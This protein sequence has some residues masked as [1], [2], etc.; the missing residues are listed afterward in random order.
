[1]VFRFGLRTGVFALCLAGLAACNSSDDGPGNVATGNRAPTVSAGADQTVGE[2]DAVTLAGTASDADGDALTYSWSQTDG[3]GVT[4]NGADTVTASFTAPDVAPGTTITLTFQLTVTD[5]A[6]SATDTVVVNV[7]EALSL[8][9]VSGRLTYERPGFNFRCR[10]LDFNNITLEPVRRAT[11][12]LLDSAGN[13]LAASRTDDNGTYAFAGINANTDVRVRVRAELL[14]TSGPQTW[15]VYVRDN[16]VDTG[17]SFA[18]RPIYVIEWGLFN[19]GITNSTDNDFTA[20]TGW[21]GVAYTGDR[22]AAP[23][24]ILD[25]ILD[26]ILLVTAVD[27]VIDLGRL[28]VFWSIDN[29]WTESDDPAAGQLVTAFY[30]SN[31]EF[32]DDFTRNPSLFLRGDA[33]GRFPDT[34][35]IN[36]DEFDSYVTLHEWGHFFEDE[37]SR[38]DSIGGAHWIPGTV[39]A[40]V[41]FGEGWGNAIGAIASGEVIGCDTGNPANSGSDLNME[42]FNSFTDEQGFFNEMSVATLLYDLWD[43]NNDGADTGSIG[44]GPI[45]ETMT[46]FQRDTAAFTTLFSFAT[47]LRQNVDPNDIAL[48]DALLEQENVDTGNLDAWASGQVTQPDFWHNGKTV[49]D[50]LPLY[51]EI[52]PG[53]PAL[54]LCVNDDQVIEQHGNKPGEWRYLRFTL[55]G[56]Q[57]LTLQIVANP[58]PPDLNPTA[59]ER[60]RAD[61]DVFLYK[62]GVFREAS[63]SGDADQEIFVM[64]SLEP[65]TYTLAFQD[66][67]YEDGVTDLDPPAKHPDYPSRVCFD[68]TLN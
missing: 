4:L 50:L 5:G 53:E 15:E 38:S 34:V 28:D 9:T 51:T 32:P 59:N 30:T 57:N 16:T 58:P 12:L 23:L 29:S 13:E 52:V 48:V 8:V 18:T 11:V 68:F 10:G 45:Y 46:G 6:A 31:P 19:T 3:P 63:R 47:G 44:F 66:W 54:N 27:P 17:P 36:T 56:T 24:A 22:A 26:G 41:A 42:T 35:A 64:G 43:T 60:D 14:Q 7:V 2:G 39:E 1:M 55:A 33:V 49:R 62:S 21:S 40:R 25:S 37:I 67:R 20:R 61:P 65:G